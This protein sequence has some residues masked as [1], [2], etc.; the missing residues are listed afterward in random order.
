MLQVN[1]VTL[2]T[3]LIVNGMIIRIFHAFLLGDAWLAFQVDTFMG[4]PL[5]HAVVIL[6]AIMIVRFT[7]S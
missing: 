4:W 6:G 7:V 3:M 5:F 2:G 1:Y